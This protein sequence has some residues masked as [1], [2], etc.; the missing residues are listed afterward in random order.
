MRLTRAPAPSYHARDRVAPVSS[1]AM[2]RTLHRAVA[3]LL[4][5]L[6]A[7]T[8]C[9][10]QTDEIVKK[11]D[12]FIKWLQTDK[13]V[14]KRRA[15]V[16]ALGLI[17]PKDRE[18]GSAL[19]LA[20]RED[21]EPI[22]R[23]QVVSVLGNMKKEELRDWVPRLAD[24]LKNDKDAGVRA[25]AAGVLGR[26]GEL[27]K[28]VMSNLLAAL[29]DEDAAT[30][31]EAAEAVSKIG[32]DAKAAIP[33]IAALLKDK[34]LRVRLAA[35]VAL[36]RFG[37][38]AATA[39]DALAAVLKDETAVDIRR[40][41]IRALG[42]LGSAA[43]AGV[44]VL[45]KALAEDKS[46]EVR[47]QAILTLGRLGAD[48]REA[49]PALKLALKNDKDKTVREFAVRTLPA[50]LGS[51]AK[52]AVKDLAE[53]LNVDPDGTVRLA[54]V[55][56]LGALGP[57]AKDAIPALTIAQRDIQVGVREAAS[58]ALKKIEAKKE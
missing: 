23:Q 48:A 44:P 36:G 47:R 27:A 7:A 32:E 43:K 26:L 40:E 19:A 31:A 22:V 30:R 45:A 5:L 50:V 11:K 39:V 15:A 16:V 20:L 14:R 12:E 4:P 6:F 3:A 51:D 29:K 54:I 42:L 38:D 13:D 28:P 56:E 21:T 57:A 10:A 53:R 35:V 18:V 33:D 55:Q 52:D 37:P 17:G 41:I 25:G 2:S 8:L 46:D 9:P 34:E 24:V 1:A 58:A 49:L